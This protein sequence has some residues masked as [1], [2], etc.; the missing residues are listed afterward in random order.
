MAVAVTTGRVQLELLAVMMS[1]LP[2]VALAVP[3]WTAHRRRRATDPGE[4]H[5]LFRRIVAELVVGLVFLAGCGYQIAMAPG[6]Y[7]T[8]L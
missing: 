2:V 8:I 4:R 1:A 6:S 3:I 5:D 7:Y